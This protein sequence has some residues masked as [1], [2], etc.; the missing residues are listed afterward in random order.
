MTNVPLTAL[1]HQRSTFHAIS[2]STRLPAAFARQAAEPDLSLF[3]DRFRLVESF[4]DNRRH[5]QG[6]LYGRRHMDI[7][8]QRCVFSWEIGRRYG[9]V[10]LFRETA[11]VV[12][13][14]V[15]LV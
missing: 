14:V 13:R 1:L 3:W 10:G 7:D 15:N 11:G 4:G 8:G 6:L 9:H 5:P 2:S 12:E